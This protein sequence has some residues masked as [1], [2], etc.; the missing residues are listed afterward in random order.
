MSD[1]GSPQIRPGGASQY[2]VV[3]VGASLAGCTAA[4]LLARNG[5][6]VALLEKSPDPDAFKRVCS[7]FIQSSAVATLQRLELLGPMEE[8][9]AVRAR[10][11]I[12]TRWGWIVPPESDSV[13]RCINLRRELL[14]P[15]IRRKAAD[16][17][18]VEL[19][20]GWSAHGLMRDGDRVCGVEARDTHGNSRRLRARLVVGGDGRGSRVAKLAGVC[21]R[22]APNT[23]FAYGAYFKGPAPAGA[24]DGLAWALDPDWGLAAPT[25]SGLTF[26]AALATKRHLPEFRREPAAALRAY[27]AALP[28]A[29]P[30]LASRMVGPPIG[31]IDLASVAH[32]PTAPGL[33]L[34]GD[35]ALATDPLWAVGCG[36]ALQSSELLADAVAPALGG[37]EPL[38]RALRRYR[39][40]RSRSLR[41]HAAVIDDYAKGRM[42]KPSERLILSAATCD[43]RVAHTLE[44]FATRNIGPGQ[45]LASALPRA[46]VVNTRW[47]IARRFNGSSQRAGASGRLGHG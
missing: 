41:A 16:T 40:R 14:D 24:P 44:A 1:P 32:T 22:S 6:R 36:W 12:R 43:K 18:G 33:A 10:L 46:A 26:Y 20:L 34:V 11:R 21:E 9:G 30:I 23:R 25:D 39:R 38:Q 42:F 13:P 35:A 31:R 2:D 8:A 15:L 45:M 7:H 17:A 3:I 5:A 19:I 47:S 27:I 29:P 28:E 4:I 37:A